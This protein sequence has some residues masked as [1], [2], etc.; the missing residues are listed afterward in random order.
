LGGDPVKGNQEMA[1]ELASYGDRFIGYLTYN[2]HYRKTLEPVIDAFFRNNF[3][4]GFKLHPDGWQLPVSHRLYNP[5]WEYADKHSLPVLI[6]TWDTPMDSPGMFKD[7]CGKYPNAR[8]L[9]GHSGGGDAGRREAVDLA[10]DNPNVILEFC[11]SFCASQ[12]WDETIAA[13]G[14]D[15]VVFGS[16]SF[17][18]DLGWELGRLLSTPLPDKELVPILGG[19]MENILSNTKINKR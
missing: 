8:F 13:V 6:H 10:R 4:K 11:G 2:P 17:L 5:A 9:L 12:P 3:Y 16:D 14:S 19:N 18:H 7:I 15:R 1:D